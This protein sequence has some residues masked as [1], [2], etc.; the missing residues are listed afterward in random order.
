MTKEELKANEYLK[1]VYEDVDDILATRQAY[2]DG[3]RDGQSRHDW[4]II[5]LGIL[6]GVFI[7]I[8]YFT[9]HK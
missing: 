6:I 2:V 5:L 7:T 8:I 3:Y 1:E 9:Y 4:S